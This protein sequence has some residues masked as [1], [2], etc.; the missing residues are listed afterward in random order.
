[1]CRVTMSQPAMPVSSPDS[2]A[3]AK[4][5]QV[6]ADNAAQSAAQ[7]RVRCE[8]KKAQLQQL[9]VEMD[10]QLSCENHEGCHSPAE[11]LEVSKRIDSL[12]LKGCSSPTQRFAH[13]LDL[14][15]GNHVVLDKL[16]KRI[17][18]LEKGCR[19]HGEGMISRTCHC[20]QCCEARAQREQKMA[21]VLGLVAEVSRKQSGGY[22]GHSVGVVTAPRAA[23][24]LRSLQKSAGLCKASTESSVDKDGPLPACAHLMRRA[25]RQSAPSASKFTSDPGCLS[26]SQ[27]I[28][29]TTPS[30]ICRPRS[31]SCV[32][33]Q[34][35]RRRFSNEDF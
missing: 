33:E 19:H 2:Q 15:L 11:V 10:A 14:T 8:E 16:Q 9:K 28:P 23:K 6:R 31:A 30:E 32:L 35:R 7:A 24:H 26:A 5:M 12:Y 25:R 4:R 13:Q 34:N 20:V 3:R 1:M 21:E 29:A 22:R 18:S 17:D 27:R